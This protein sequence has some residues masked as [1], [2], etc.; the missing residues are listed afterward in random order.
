MHY[1]R[2][3]KLRYSTLITALGLGL[4]TLAAHAQ[5]VPD[6]GEALR[7]S[8]PAAPP[9]VPQPAL[10]AIG[11][12]PTEPPM[13]AL[14]GGSATVQVNEI[15][16]VGNRVI[17]SATL[18]SLVQPDQ[19]KALSLAQLDEIAT[20]I[21]R[22]YRA[23]GYFVTRAYVP[24]QELVGGK[25]T[26]RVVEGNYGRFILDNKSLVRDSV[27]Q[28]L[29]DDIKDSDIVSLDT[30]E[31]AMLI[32]N[33]T[34]GVQ[35]V[36]ADVMP[37]QKVGT[38]DF[39]VGT[40]ATAPYNG[41][42]LLDNHGSVYTGKERL[43]FSADWNSPSGRGDRLSASG[44]VTRSSGL[45]N[46]RLGYSSLVAPN[47]T[48]AEVALSRTQYELGDIYAA[49]GAT[50]TASSVELNLTTPLKRTREQSVE[51][52]LGAAYRDLKD[53]VGATST[54]TGKK[55]T[56]LNASVSARTEH[57]LFG[58]DGLTQAGAVVTLGQLRFGDSASAA[59]DA[60][61]TNTQGH[62]AKLSLS[63]VRATL[64]PA[65]FSLTTSAKAQWSLNRKNLDG[66]ERM[67]VSGVGGV[68]A[69]PS[70][71][72]SGDN[73]AL[74]RA[75]LARPVPL[76][77]AVRLSASVFADYGWA[78]AAQPLAGA[79][80]RKLGDVGVGL[81]ANM[82]GGLLKLQ[83]AHRVSGGEP[84]SEAAARTRVLLQGGWVF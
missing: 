20:R 32:I 62:Y 16:V 72:L 31:R 50:G 24:A 34:P 48:R 60:A 28:G 33:D 38:S 67:S 63:L 43:S 52:G 55:T 23:Q 19:G 4:S 51:G 40:A 56:S 8:R 15:A 3:H 10:P 6:I 79:G 69:Y 61:G 18:L 36:R 39:A 66:S 82:A 37:G 30:L 14:P 27:V 29:L 64:L 53:E 46:G 11:G 80:G 7:Q 13:A 35:V 77:G 78:K 74:V 73:A 45:L 5:A 21:T 65:Q 2:H 26:L 71:E 83:L 58:F 47:G 57:R 68:S 70:G 49:L 75:E 9:T 44:M 84:T 12:A 25:V 17:D 59:L 41:Y 76:S 42:V 54:V 22:Y 1:A 81:A